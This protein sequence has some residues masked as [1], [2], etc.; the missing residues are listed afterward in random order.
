MEAKRTESNL[1]ALHTRIQVNTV[2]ESDEKHNKWLGDTII[3]DFPNIEF[4]PCHL[5]VFFQKKEKQ[6]QEIM[7][8]S[9]SVK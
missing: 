4:Q 2:H 5:L 6:I 3:H 1:P 8:C 9:C 7:F